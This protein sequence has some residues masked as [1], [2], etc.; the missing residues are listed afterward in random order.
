MRF[1]YLSNN[2][3][4]QDVIKFLFGYFYKN[5]NAFVCVFKT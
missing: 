2:L 4:K 3:H 1:N 5:Q